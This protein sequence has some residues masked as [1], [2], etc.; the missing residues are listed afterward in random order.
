MKNMSR[1]RAVEV[2][3]LNLP[4]MLAVLTGTRAREWK[5]RDGPDS[6]CGV[7]YYYGHRQGNEAYINI[8]Q[9]HFTI[10]VAGETLF[11]GDPAK[12]PRL[13]RCVS[14]Y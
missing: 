12:D 14:E 3:T 5:L 8:D 10:S 4:G 9:G 6:G 7:D 1:K 11:T 13:K 2:V